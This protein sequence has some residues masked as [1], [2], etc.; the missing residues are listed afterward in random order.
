MNILVTQISRVKKF[1]LTT[2]QKGSPSFTSRVNKIG[3]ANSNVRMAAMA[4]GLLNQAWASVR[5]L[6]KLKHGKISG[7]QFKVLD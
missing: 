1:F 4:K 3:I 6:V 5:S 2:Y 7:V